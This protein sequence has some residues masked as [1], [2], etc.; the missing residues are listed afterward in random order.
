MPKLCLLLLPCVAALA[1]I[2]GLAS[3]LSPDPTPG[4]PV[5]QTTITAIAQG[6]IIAT[7]LD[8]SA[9]ATDLIRLQDETTG[10][11]S[12]WMMNNKTSTAGQTFDFGAVNAGDKLAF[13]IESNSILDPNGYWVTSGGWID[14]TESSDSTEAT[15][16]VSSFYATMQDGT[17]LLGAED[18]PR[19]I[20]PEYGVYYTSA[21][22][23][24]VV[25]TVSNAS[26]GSTLTPEPG[27]F[28]LLGTGLLG[29]AG[30]IRRR[31]AS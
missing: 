2:S 24:N 21:D 5:A 1:P 23:K 9:D 3:V 26:G 30:A 14:P 18:I 28:V 6:D 31:L 27:T 13:E 4:I 20:S 12:A 10:T 17:L 22:Y 25:F 8:T 19:K 11:Y 7:F 16:G 15:D 29:A